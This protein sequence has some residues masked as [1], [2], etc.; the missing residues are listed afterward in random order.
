MNDAV[1]FIFGVFVWLLGLCVGSFLNVVVYR[2][3]A[4]LSLL[5]PRWSFCPRCRHTL[6]WADNLPLIS[7]LAL[8]GRCR[9]CRAPISAQYPLVEAVTGLAFALV[10]RLLAHDHARFG[11]DEFALGT[12]WPL[13][14]AWLTLTAAMIAC[15][16]TD[17]VSYSIDTR[18]TNFTLIA[19]L[20]L[21]A[22]WPRG[23]FLAPVAESQVAAATFVALI[24]SAIMLWRFAPAEEIEGAS[25]GG[26]GDDKFADETR[27]PHKSSAPAVRVPLIGVFAAALAAILLTVT[28]LFTRG[29]DSTQPD[30]A[31]TQVAAPLAIIIMF[32]IM[33]AAGGARRDADDEIHAEIEAERPFARRV[34]LSE[35]VWLAPIV[36]VGAI[37]YWLAGAGPLASGWETLVAW[38]P[39]GNN[40]P[41][42]TP[43]AGIAYAAH[44]AILA[45]AAGWI[46][47]IF[48]TLVF[49][50]EA[51]GV[52]DIFILAAAGATIGWDLALL[53]FLLAIPLALVGWIIGLALKQTVMIPFGPWL[54]IGFL[55]A[56]WLSRPAAEIGMRYR[57]LFTEIARDRPQALL[58]LA[59]VLIVGMALAIGLSRLLRRFV[60]GRLAQ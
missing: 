8:G 45:A 31:M 38:T 2:L 14:L 59:G 50:R 27:E 21:M 39:L 34:A 46:V 19:G 54:G 20:I 1:I 40:A 33:V 30:S 35:C 36:G 28:P 16:A 25:D 41:P 43:I 11:L 47:R 26:A 51:F 37:A 23:G 7:W 48:F 29:A 24:A 5:H 44:G 12:D 22:L 55:A 60:E 49:G 6:A 9:Y 13:L 53:G 10:W 32:A 3:P 52:G 58:G 15:A 56:L 4:G 42:V 17:V 57:D 18:V